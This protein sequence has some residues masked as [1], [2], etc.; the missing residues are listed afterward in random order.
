MANKTEK[1]K[2]ISWGAAAPPTPFR[3]LFRNLGE[4]AFTFSDLEQQL[5]ETIQVMLG[6]SWQEAAA[7]R[8]AAVPPTQS[9]S[10]LMNPPAV[11][12]ASGLAVVGM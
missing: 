11:I 5:N 3:K 7:M 10:L 6:T 8:P 9:S 1:S 4:L 12:L 2:P